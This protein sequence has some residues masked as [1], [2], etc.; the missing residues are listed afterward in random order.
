VVVIEKE[1]GTTEVAAINPVAS[2]M[3]VENPALQT[4]AGDVAKTLRNV[5]ESL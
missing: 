4:Y 1:N 2:M 3:T 5:I